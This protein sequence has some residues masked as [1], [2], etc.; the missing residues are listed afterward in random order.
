[1]NVMSIQDA[2]Q[3]SDIVP[4]L[5]RIRD[6]V[7]VRLD[8]DPLPVIP[9]FEKLA[10]IILDRP[11][12]RQGELVRNVLLE[13]LPELT[14][15]DRKA[16]RAEFG[17]DSDIRFLRSVER[18]TRAA[19]VY[20]YSLSHFRQRGL[21]ERLLTQIAAAIVDLARSRLAAGPQMLNGKAGILDQDMP[22]DSPKRQGTAH[23]SP[24][25]SDPVP[26]Q[27]PT[28]IGDFVGRDDAITQLDRMLGRDTNPASRAVIISA[29]DGT[30][31]AG[32]TTLAVHWAHRVRER[33]PDGDLFIN[34]R[35]YDFSAPVTA[36]EALDYFLRALGVSPKKIP[37]GVDEKAGLFRTLLHD[38]RMLV[39]LDN[40]ATPDQVRPLLPASANCLVLVTSRSRLSGLTTTH[41]ARRITLDLLSELESVELLR[42]MTARNGPDDEIQFMEMSRLCSYL[43]LALR[44]AGERAVTHPRRSLASLVAELEDETGRLDELSLDDEST[45][46]RSVFSWSYKS[47]KDTDARM[48]RL[49]GVQ[50]GAD[51]TMPA[52]AALAGLPPHAARASLASLVRDHLVEEGEAGRYGFHDLLR[53]YA[54]E[55]AEQ[56]EEPAELRSGVERLATWYLHAA[57]SANRMIMPQRQSF[58]LHPLEEP[59]EVPVLA[60]YARA[61]AWCESERSNLTRVV[62][63]ADEHGLHVPAWQLAVVLRGFFN[64]RKH[65]TDWTTTHEV[66]L[67]AA[68]A[69]GDPYGEGRVLNGLGTVC[70]QLGR[71]EEAV[72]FHQEALMN[73]V[74][75]GDTVGQA[76]ALDSL[77]NAQ[78]ETG[79]FDLAIESYRK[80]L[81]L[82]REISDRHGQAWCLNNLGEAYQSLGEHAHAIGY[83]TDALLLRRE[84]QDHWGEGRTLHNLGVSHSKSAQV[85]QGMEYLAQAL[86][87]RRGL[88]DRWGIAC[89][90]H[91]LAQTQ[92]D[93]GHVEAARTAWA[94]ALTLFNELNDPQA[95]EVREALMGVRAPW[96]GH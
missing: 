47:L 69:A 20:G 78:R 7:P 77:G 44:I 88:E 1:M 30:A 61:M 96:S 94:E 41:S 49:L 87:I 82:R 37:D 59:A 11:P 22:T 71:F 43:P 5:K 92:L 39:V 63:Q 52:A 17:L 23:Q 80:S 66:A 12:T 6:R 67:T 60:D 27:L 35:G 84:V 90:L 46:V 15:L 57:E 62:V 53:S 65:W 38:K 50:A 89:T 9:H 25:R 75:I 13:I 21:E 91:Q 26:R 24:S 40:A 70:K 16:L 72:A 86:A 19:D 56:Q 2:G 73:R 81:D 42:E 8:V 10:L 33:F 3:V 36:A 45:A 34:L 4:E 18:R 58:P 51:I 74:A 83:L 64:I 55:R 31:G 32:K 79:C 95:D 76:S 54:K 29:I 68:R 14:E 48:F 93:L 28:T 85:Q